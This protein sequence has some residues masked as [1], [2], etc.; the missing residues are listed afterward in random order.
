MNDRLT[1][2]EQRQPRIITFESTYSHPRF[3]G[4]PDDN[5]LKENSS[6]V[7]ILNGR[8]ISEVFA[9]DTSELTEAGV[10][11]DQAIHVLKC[12]AISASYQDEQNSQAFER[13]RI[14]IFHG[15]ESY[16]A[17]LTQQKQYDLVVK[18]IL[19]DHCV[20]IGFGGHV[21]A[22]ST[23]ARVQFDDPINNALP[24]GDPSLFD[25]VALRGPE[26]QIAFTSADTNFKSTINYP[27]LVQAE[28]YHLL[29]KGNQYAMTGAQLAL[30]VHAFGETEFNTKIGQWL[31]QKMDD[32]YIG[33][34]VIKQHNEVIVFEGGIQIELTIHNFGGL[35]LIVFSKPFTRCTIE[36]D[37]GVIKE[38]HLSGVDYHYAKQIIA[39]KGKYFRRELGD[40]W[41]DSD[42]M[43]PVEGSDAESSVCRAAEILLQTAKAQP[44]GILKDNAGIVYTLAHRVKAIVNPEV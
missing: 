8:L 1:K 22:Q 12:L 44:D 7:G 6:M 14:Q 31:R 10:S 21:L 34:S 37:N 33:L 30:L 15:K 2:L 9:S 38:I 3:V 35:D 42:K 13:A 26:K 29:E 16:E 27:T 17:T 11:W 4:V 36:Q 39:I 41:G 43:I 5:Q 25:L 32:E 23:G 19:Q 24:Q 20:L 18:Q 40:R 28:K